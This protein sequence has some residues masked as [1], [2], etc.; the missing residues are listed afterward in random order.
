MDVD[1]HLLRICYL[2]FLHPVMKHH[3]DRVAFRLRCMLLICTVEVRKEVVLSANGT[4]G[5]VDGKVPRSLEEGQ[6]M[7]MNTYG[8]EKKLTVGVWQ[9]DSS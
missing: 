1:L 7:E 9:W 2:L 8:S 4:G 3:L 5:V 6:N